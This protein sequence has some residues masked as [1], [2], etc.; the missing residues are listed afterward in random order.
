M[1]LARILLLLALVAL[2]ACDRAAPSEP[3]PSEASG[4]PSEVVAEGGFFD[5]ELLL[6]GAMDLAE[7][8]DLPCPG[9][10]DEERADPYH[11]KVLRGL[12]LAPGGQL[13]L[14][15]PSFFPDWLVPQAAAAPL[16]GER[17]VAG[18]PVE[19]RHE[20]A[21]LLTTTTTAS[22]RWCLRI[23]EG[24]EPGPG[25]MLVARSGEVELRRLLFHT[26]DADLHA[27]PEAIVRILDAQAIDTAAIPNT[28]FL[29][30]EVL[31]QT[32]DDLLEPV[33]LS[34]AGDLEQAVARLEEVLLRDER[35]GAM[36][37][38]LPRK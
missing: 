28:T 9:A 4:A 38:R 27:L 33:D 32:A 22:G 31:A 8:A 3:S 5:E 24:I 12:V 36:L 6:E 2:P 26:G 23:P 18:V 37:A 20:G 25:L 35:L 34:D 30:L 19:L 29:N 11:P 16:E 21:S 10:T 13:A 17:P 15:R 14:R 1:N 7:D